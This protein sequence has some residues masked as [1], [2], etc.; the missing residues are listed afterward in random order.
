MPEPAEPMTL[1]L[2]CN[3]LVVVDE[4][5]RVYD[6]TGLVI[7]Q[8]IQDDGLTLK[9]FVKLLPQ[10]ERT[11]ANARHMTRLSE[12]LNLYDGEEEAHA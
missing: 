5:G 6:R 1:R 7:D 12:S 10:D 8:Q 2:P 9:V 11:R 4:T 3:R